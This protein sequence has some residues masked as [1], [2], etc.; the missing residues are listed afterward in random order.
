MTSTT[1]IWRLGFGGRI[2]HA[3]HQVGTYTSKFA[4]LCR[5]GLKYGN[6]WEA[7]SYDRCHK[8]EKLL[9]KMIKPQERSK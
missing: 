9:A 7:P 1:Y 5:P 6:G 3:W 8:C 2:L 4:A